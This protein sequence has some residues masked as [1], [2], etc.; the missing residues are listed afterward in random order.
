MKA[1]QGHKDIIEARRFIFDTMV[2]ISKGEVSLEQGL[3][4]HKLASDLME[5]YRLQLKAVELSISNSAI[6]ITVKEATKELEG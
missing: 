4:Q 2:G 5:G 1:K 6:P 3:V